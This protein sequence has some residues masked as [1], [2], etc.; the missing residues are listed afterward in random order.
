MKRI[1]QIL[2]YIALI[3]VVLISVLISSSLTPNGFKRGTSITI[4]KGMGLTEVANLLKAKDVIRS[5]TTFKIYAITIEGSKGLKAGDYLFNDRL[6]AYE[7]ANRIVE[8]VGGYPL[9]KVTIPEG[10][11]SYVIARILKKSLSDFDTSTFIQKAKKYEGYMFPDTYF[12]PTNVKTETI[13]SDMTRLFEAK[14]RALEDLVGTSNRTLGDAVILA[15][16]VER[17]ATSTADRK[18]VAGILWKRLDMHMPLQADATFY[19]ALGT[20]TRKL[21]L[22]D[23]K[24]DSPYNLYT[25][26]GLP[27]GPISNPGLD[28]LA[29]TLAPTKSKYL[30]YISGKD[31]NTHYAATLEEHALNKFKYLY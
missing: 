20:T 12:W 9:V 11:D 26:A 7:V 21:T 17:E 31:G 8:G 25:H 15:S 22:A 27:P 2:V 18:L 6:S 28:A 19:Y 5:T 3:L 14:T 13:I 10:S 30:Y 24:M 1:K 29:D 16:I 23:L 4:E